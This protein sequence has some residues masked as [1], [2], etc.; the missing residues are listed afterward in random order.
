MSPFGK[1]SRGSV[2][3]FLL[4]RCRHRVVVPYSSMGSSSLGSV[5]RGG[6]SSSHPLWKCSSSQRRH[7]E[8]GFGLRRRWGRCRSS[9]RGRRNRGAEVRAGVVDPHPDAEGE[10][11]R[12]EKG[13]RPMG[14]KERE[15]DAR[16]PQWVVGI[17]EE[18][19]GVRVREK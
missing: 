3:L 15:T 16:G 14:E 12:N 5:V 9:L 13:G 1:R 19:E 18:Y 2:H 4:L 6:S 17:E 8:G 11:E 7:V 10:R